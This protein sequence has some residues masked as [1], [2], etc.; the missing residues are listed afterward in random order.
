MP[1]PTQI[2]KKRHLAETVL[3]IRWRR[4]RDSNPREAL[5]PTRFPVAPIRPLWHLSAVVRAVKMHPDHEK[6]PRAGENYS[7]VAGASAPTHYGSCVP[8]L[9]SRGAQRR[10]DPGAERD[11]VAI[12]RWPR[13]ARNDQWGELGTHEPITAQ[14]DRPRC[15]DGT[16]TS[17]TRTKSDWGYA[18][19]QRR[20][21]PRSPVRFP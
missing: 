17:R 12:T 5:T 16:G 20:D 19:T 14:A 10:G 1:F 4:G 7:T 11:P 13:C 18:G 21:Q 6:H 9:S 8:S 3:N 2:G 15:R